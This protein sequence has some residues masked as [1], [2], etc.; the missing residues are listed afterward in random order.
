V[1]DCEP[2]Q[3]LDRIFVVGAFL[4]HMEVEEGL[5]DLRAGAKDMGAGLAG[6]AV[7]DI[8]VEAA[9]VLGQGMTAVAAGCSHSA[10]PHLE[11]FHFACTHPAVAVGEHAAASGPAS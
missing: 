1:L 3:E 4:C 11:Y 2:V 7:G 5:E 10:C 8:A 9:R 6:P